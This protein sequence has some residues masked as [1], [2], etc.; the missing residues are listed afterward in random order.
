MNPCHDVTKNTPSDHSNGSSSTVSVPPT[1]DS[2]GDAIAEPLEP[3]EAS[4]ETQKQ[5]NSSHHQQQYHSTSSPDMPKERRGVS[6]SVFLRF[7]LVT[8]LLAAAGICASLAYVSLSR[9]EV[10]TAEF[11]YHSISI[12]A[13]N[14]AKAIARRQFQAAELTASIASWANPEV[15]N[16]PFIRVPG[17]MDMTS[18]VATLT[19]STTQALT[20]LVNPS[21]VEE[22]EAHIQQLYREEGRPAEAGMS[23]FGFGVWKPDNSSNFPDGR[24][25]DT[26]GE[27]SSLSFSLCF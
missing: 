18:K 9:A 17:Y 3:K 25:H 27:V 16:W 13:L 10:D 24:V 5:P 8:S 6:R 22:F 21:Q 19:S 2:S 20:V 23:D 7:I 15:D 1:L 4:K 11:S 26:T 14:N 12:S